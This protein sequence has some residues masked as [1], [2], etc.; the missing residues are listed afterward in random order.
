MNYSIDTIVW[1]VALAVALASG[2]VG[3]LLTVYRERTYGGHKFEFGVS[4]SD[5]E[6]LS[7]AD[8]SAWRHYR[9]L[10]QFVRLFTVTFWI[11]LLFCVAL[12]LTMVSVIIAVAIPIIL[13]YVLIRFRKQWQR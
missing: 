6:R 2:A 5:Y 7:A 1:A 13:I 10:S 4:D 8:C 11:M 9:T 3:Y 12:S